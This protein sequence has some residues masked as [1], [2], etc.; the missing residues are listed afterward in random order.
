MALKVLVLLEGRDVCI[1]TANVLDGLVLY[2]VT[3]RSLNSL[4]CKGLS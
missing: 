3:V 2:C 4:L 1:T